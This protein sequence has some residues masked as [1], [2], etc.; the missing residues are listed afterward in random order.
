MGL[1]L[2]VLLGLLLGLLE[3]AIGDFPMRYFLPGYWGYICQL[4]EHV[5]GQHRVQED[6]KES[7]TIHKRL[8]TV[9]VQII[10]SD[11]FHHSSPW[12]YPEVHHDVSRL[13]S[14]S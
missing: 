6:G 12:P 8:L 11:C 4:G 2:G 10:K 5:F 1:L 13:R 14:L 7:K 3:F 9:T